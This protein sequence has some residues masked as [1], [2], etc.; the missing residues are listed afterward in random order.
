MYKISNPRAH[1]YV[2][3]CIV[4]RE[5]D[6]LPRFA[7]SSTCGDVETQDEGGARL[8]LYVHLF[9]D[10][11][12]HTIEDVDICLSVCLVKKNSSNA[13]LP[14][15]FIAMVA[16]SS[17]FLINPSQVFEHSQVNHCIVFSQ[18]FLRFPNPVWCHDFL[19]CLKLICI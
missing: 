3:E 5:R 1:V 13:R 9:V 15:G 19:P 17:C 12:E 10:H 14:C 4:T 8:I 7:V 2:M 11:I 16:R 18:P 6:R